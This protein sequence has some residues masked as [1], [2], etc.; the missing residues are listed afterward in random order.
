VKTCDQHQHNNSTRQV[1]IETPPAEDML[2]AA[3]M[4]SEPLDK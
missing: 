4:T 2:R 1:G 3:D